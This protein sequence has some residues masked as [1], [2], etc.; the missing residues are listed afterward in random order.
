VESLPENIVYQGR[1]Q[2]NRRVQELINRGILKPKNEFPTDPQE[3]EYY[4]SAIDLLLCRHFVHGII[5]K[6]IALDQ[7]VAKTILTLLL[8]E[9]QGDIFRKY[10]LGCEEFFNP[11]IRAYQKLDVD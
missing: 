2:L 7:I 4:Q 5:N 11:L 8:N 6:K 9:K 10:N 1:E 3:I